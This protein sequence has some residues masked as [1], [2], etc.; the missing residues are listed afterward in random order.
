MMRPSSNLLKSFL[1]IGIAV[2]LVACEEEK[3][4]VEAPIRAVKTMVVTERA[5][6]Q[7]RRIAGITESTIVTD[8]AFQVAGRVVTMDAEVGDRVEK[9]AVIAAPFPILS[10]GPQALAAAGA[11][12]AAG[13]GAPPLLFSGSS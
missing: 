11:G 5:G 12:E 3:V 13:F 2:G 4:V 1:L 6:A 8:L 9:G 10:E 7:E